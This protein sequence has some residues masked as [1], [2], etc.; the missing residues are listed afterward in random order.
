MRFD[1]AL[2]VAVNVLRQQGLE[3]RLP[4]ATF[5]R[6]P[7]G[8]LALVLPDDALASNSW[9]T[10]AALLHDTLKRWSPGLQRVL[11]R[12]SDL[13]D[14]TDVLGSPDRIQLTEEGGVWLVDRLL[15]NQDWLRDGPAK[16]SIPTAA[17]FSLKGGVGR[18]TA[19]AVLAWHLAR[20]GRRVLVI[21]LD[22][23]APG[24]GA[25]LLPDLPD[26][27]VIDW[28]VEALVGAA[29]SELFERMILPAPMANGLPGNVWVTPAFGRHTRDYVAKL[30]RAYMP[31]VEEERLVGLA[32]RL[33]RLLDEATRRL[34][35]PEILLLDARA[36]LHDIGSAVVTQLGAEVLMFGRN[37]P[38]TWA[39]YGHLFQHLRHARSIKWG[40][41]EEDLRWRLKMVAAQTEPTTSAVEAWIRR[42]YL[43][44]TDIYDAEGKAGDTAKTDEPVL[45]AERD[46]A[47][48]HYPLN[49]PFDTQV[50][51]IDFIDSSRRPD[52]DFLAS[53][54][55]AFLDGATDRLLADVAP[56]EAT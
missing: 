39:A 22:L 54:F 34:E 40:M 52:W 25:M 9:E 14:S 23:E 6:D 21:D 50:R 17:A 5:V 2:P 44:W 42:S 37:D 13:V 41:P 33:G 38:S 3:R 47:A 1:D 55:G 20:L 30:G 43:V 7:S 19:L 48:P 12:Q 15:T 26:F 56:P 24:I 8:S 4:D 16:A 29:D 28:C 35:P 49:I 11:L 10:I 45:F 46:E 36:G 27:G 32:E 53:V 18:S 31:A 51:G